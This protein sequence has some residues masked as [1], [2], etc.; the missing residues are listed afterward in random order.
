MNLN[1]MQEWVD[2]VKTHK[3]SFLNSAKGS[4]VPPT[5]FVE[6]EGK[7]LAVLIAPGM[8]KELLF[9]AAAICR[10]GLAADAFVAMFDAHMATA[11]VKD[12]SEDSFINKYPPGSMQRMASEG[13]CEKGL[14]TECLVCHRITVDKKIAMVTVPYAE[15]NGNI[16]WKDDINIINEDNDPAL[17]GNIPHALR[18]IIG[19]PTFMEDEQVQMMAKFCHVEPEE[20]IKYTTR[21]A[22][23]VLANQGFHVADYSEENNGN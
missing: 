12:E 10:K 20:Q 19:M 3:K 13:A 22:L 23:S 6:R 8:D 21:S 18:N 7:L 14:I 5:L 11:S 9:Q 17:Q 15:V 16:Q 2:V 4:N 1:N